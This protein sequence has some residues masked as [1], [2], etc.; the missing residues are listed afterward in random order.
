MLLSRY[1]ISN[2]P[3]FPIRYFFVSFQTSSYFSFFPPW[4]FRLYCIPLNA[5]IS[6]SIH[7]SLLPYFVRKFPLSIFQISF[8]FFNVSILH[9][10]FLSFQIPF[11]LSSLSTRS[12]Y[13]I[14]LSGG[15]K[16][17]RPFWLIVPQ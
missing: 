17:Q 2:R 16:R 9:S 15:I 3:Y 11:L 8:P 1:L 7:L 14:C 10:C 13:F 5:S 12:S 6:L 4:I